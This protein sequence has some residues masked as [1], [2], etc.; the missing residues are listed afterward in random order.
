MRIL[1]TA[2]Q[3]G[4]VTSACALIQGMRPGQVIADAASDAGYFRDAIA[5]A[6]GQAVIANNP[7]R[8]RRIPC[9]R[10]LYR[11]RNL[12]ERC[13]LRLKAFRRVATG[14]DKTASSFLAFVTIAACTVL[15]K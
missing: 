6:G 5:A 8:A 1:L 11:E 10:A 14:Y 3:A 9:H 7:S 4:D 13:L 12:I 2:G 15:W